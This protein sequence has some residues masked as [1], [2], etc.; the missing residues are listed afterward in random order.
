[1]NPIITTEM[2]VADRVMRHLKRVT[3]VRESE[4]YNISVRPT[5]YV[6][7][8]QFAAITTKSQEEG[9]LDRSVTE[10]GGVWLALK[11][12]EGAVR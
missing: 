12:A 4:L 1:M 8:E 10:H 9:H 5:S 6:T 7:K 11:A 3:R 2:K